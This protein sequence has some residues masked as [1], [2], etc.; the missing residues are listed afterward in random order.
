MIGSPKFQSTTRIAGTPIETTR[1]DP[2]NGPG[3]D[4]TRIKADVVQ[5]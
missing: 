3:V 2:S 1:R 5:E 4:A